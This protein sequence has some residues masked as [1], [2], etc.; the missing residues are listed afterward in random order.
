[1]KRSIFI[2]L[3][4]AG[5]ILLP[6]N[7]QSSVYYVAPTGNDAAAGTIAA[8]FASMA[9]GQTAA[10]AGDTVYFRGGTYLYS[11]TS[12]A[13]GVDLTK[14]GTSTGRI[15]YWAYPNETPCFDFTGMTA[16]ARIKGINITASWIY[17]KGLEVRKVPQ[18]LTTQHESWG[19]YNN[20]GGHNVFELLNLHHNMGPGLFIVKGGSNLV[21]NCDSHHNFDPKSSSGP[22]TNADGFGCHI[23]AADTGNVFRGCRAWWNSDDGYDLIQAQEPVTIENCWA[24]YSGYLPD[25]ANAPSGGDGNGF[26]MGGYGLPPTHVPANPPHHIFRF[27]VSFFNLVNGFDHNYHPVSDYIYNN[28]SFNNK[29]SDFNMKGYNPTTSTAI[30]VGILRNNLAFT[31]TILANGAGINDSCNSWNLPVTVTAADFLTTSITGVDGPRNIDGSVPATGFLKLAPSSDCID[32]GVNV[33]LPFAGSAPD[34]GAF[35]YASTAVFRIGPGK[36]RI[37]FIPPH[38]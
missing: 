13:D 17:L 2:F 7:V 8:P 16:A 30:N 14:S 23:G 37:G 9:R 29:G 32:A 38:R 6:A 35:E 31:G 34:L 28:T 21:L 5:Y 20:G 36:R 4:M 22:G 11:S 15:K 27:C 18:N 12:A 33:G 24:W 1:M 25:S 10:T 3:T 19:I 26:K